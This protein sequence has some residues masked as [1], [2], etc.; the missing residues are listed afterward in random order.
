MVIDWG[1]HGKSPAEMSCFVDLSK[2]TNAFQLAF[3]G[4][5]LERGCHAV[6][7]SASFE[8][9]PEGAIGGLELFRPLRND[10]FCN[11]CHCQLRAF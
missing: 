1:P 8:Q 6:V 5:I 9:Q 10:R 11:V 2:A 7:E 3:G 4:C